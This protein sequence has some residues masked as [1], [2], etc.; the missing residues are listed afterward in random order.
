MAQSSLPEGVLVR[1]LQR[2]ADPRGGLAEIFREEWGLGAPAVQWN[3]FDGAA[4]SLRG[5]HVHMRHTDYLTVLRGRMLLA[6]KDA[7]RASAGFG[8]ATVVELAEARLQTVHIPPGVAHAFYF[9]APALVMNGVSHV[10]SGDDEIG[11]RWDDPELGFDWTVRDP[12]VSSRDGSAGGWRQ[13]TDAYA[14]ATG[15]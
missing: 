6:L 5:V 8:A 11:C 3:A 13:L 12:V 14:A 10:W 7:R 15:A 4:N 9:P 1:D 2:H